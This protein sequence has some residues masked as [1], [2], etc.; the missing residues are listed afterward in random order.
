MFLYKH[1]LAALNLDLR[2]GKMKQQFIQLYLNKRKTIKKKEN[3]YNFIADYVT[4]NNINKFLH[5][6][7]LQLFIFIMVLL[8]FITTKKE[9]KMYHNLFSIVGT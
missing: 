1:T 6:I 9:K 2:F 4:M 8:I 7:L 5:L 3:Q